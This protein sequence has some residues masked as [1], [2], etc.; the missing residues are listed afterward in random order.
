ME[1]DALEA[2]SSSDATAANCLAKARAS[3]LTLGMADELADLDMKT[4]AAINVANL[5][6]V[7]RASLI[8]FNA[9]P[10][11]TGQT[12][13]VLAGVLAAKTQ[14][15]FERAGRPWAL[16]SDPGRTYVEV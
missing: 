1:R 10:P 7:S 15:D 3:Y 11:T 2:I 14:A 12:A 9:T 6:P 16:Y 5:Q 4:G 13:K 8:A